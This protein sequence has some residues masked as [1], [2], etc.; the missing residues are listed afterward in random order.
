M[1]YGRRYKKYR[2]YRRRYRSSLAKKAYR[3]AKKAYKAPELKYNKISLTKNPVS[4]IGTFDNLDSTSA[5]TT[6][7]QRIGDSIIAKSIHLRCKMNLNAS[8]TAT[9]VRMLIFKWR[10]E[11]PATVTDVLET[12]TITSFKSDDQRFQSSILYDRTYNLNTDRP[13]I[14]LKKKIKLG[15]RMTYI[16]GGTV[17]NTNGVYVIFCSDEAVNTPTIDFQSRMFYIDP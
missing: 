4:G 1:A 17:P 9:Q 16:G 8:A 12:A 11:F 14:F 2:R 7:N 10:S 13:E 15:F 3:L 6:N 5:G